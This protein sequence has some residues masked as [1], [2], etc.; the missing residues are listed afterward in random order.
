MVS[1]GRNAGNIAKALRYHFAG[2]A[3]QF[4][5]VSLVCLYIYNEEENCDN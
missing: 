3:V 1:I 4:Q 5:Q 2:T